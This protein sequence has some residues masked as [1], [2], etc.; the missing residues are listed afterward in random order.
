MPNSIKKLPLIL[1]W[2][3][4][5]TPN[6]FADTTNVLPAVEVRAE[7]NALIGIADS[8]SDG[9][10]TEKQLAHRPFLRPAE[11]LE[12]VPGLIVT[13]HSGDGK[14]NQYFLRGFNLDHGSDFATYVNG[15]P[16]NMVSHAHGQGYMDLN[17]LIPELIGG[18]RYQKGPYAVEDSDFATTGSARI[19]Y[20][21]SLPAAFAAVTLGEFNY[22][23][24]LFAGSLDWQGRQILGAAEIAGYD[25]PW[26]QPQDLRKLN[27]YGSVSEG[28]ATDGY[29]LTAM[30]YQNRWVASEHVP[31]RA[32]DSGEIGRFGTLSP[33]D[34]GRTHR[35]ALSG[36]WNRSDET[37]ASKLHTYVVDYGL[38]LYSAPS[39][40]ISGPQGDQ[41]EQADHR[42]QLGGVLEKHWQLP[43]QWWD[44]EL[45]VGSQWR[46]DRIG[47]LGLYNTVDRVRTNTVRADRVN[48]TAIGVFS[49]LKT[50]WTSWLRTTLGLRF[51]DIRA[52]VNS[53]AGQFNLSNGG[54]T[55]AQQLSPKLGVVLSPWQHLEIYANWG[56]GFHS[57]DSRGAV[58]SQNP[59]DGSAAQRVP[60]I[61]KSE[62]AEIGLRA[63]PIHGW[64]TAFAFWQTKS[65]SELVFVGDEGITEPRGSSHRYGLE[66][67]NHLTLSDYWFVDA[68]AAFSKARF[69]R[70]ENGG[71]DIP[72]AIPITASLA[73]NFDDGQRWS[74]GVRA[75]FIGAYPLEETG[76]H[77]SSSFWTANARVDYQWDKHWQLSASLLNVFDRK[78]NDIEY[79]G[80]ACSRADG[81]GCGGGAGIDGRLVHPLEPRSL[82]VGAR[83]T[84]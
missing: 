53:E 22:Q 54:D 12:T 72:N 44:S 46:H 61:A 36:E 55:R 64:Q 35:I 20:K 16:I 50:P 14:A 82:R 30:A 45:I 23:R 17:F 65:A 13:Q 40:F 68:D 41:H 28:T 26:D 38:N 32:I 1:V 8:A 73:A 15:I 77:T 52:E 31:K 47:T 4:F 48:Q 2:S 37:S 5:E 60:L 27:V 80:A 10:V 43:S 83:Y 9:K 21:K 84:F 51:D 67:T 79:W 81:A 71:R 63:S 70:A 18:L 7:I 42:T 76:T 58:I 75:R 57:N 59:L 69:D 49:E 74:G 78:A 29:V 25:G 19:A 34:G 11:V 39:G 66:W 62:G 3:L 6:V 33:N 56:R 24:A